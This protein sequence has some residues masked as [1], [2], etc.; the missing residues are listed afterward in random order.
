MKVRRFKRSHFI[1]WI[2]RHFREKN[3]TFFFQCMGKV[4]NTLGLY[5]RGRLSR[6][7]ATEPRSY[8]LSPVYS[9]TFYFR[10]F[11]F[12]QKRLEKLSRLQIL[13]R[14]WLFTRATLCLAIDILGYVFNWRERQG[15]TT[16]NH[17]RISCCVDCHEFITYIRMTIATC[18]F[19]RAN[20]P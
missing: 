10:I 2:T 14:K 8:N 18:I 20:D 12:S 11:D 9:R 7:H 13:Q 4:V 1:W 5:R 6:L 16:A 3:L 15:Q 17:K 19:A